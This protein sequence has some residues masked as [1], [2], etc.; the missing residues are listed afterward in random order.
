VISSGASR[1]LPG[2]ERGE[3]MYRTVDVGSPAEEAANEAGRDAAAPPPPPRDDTTRGR[4][5]AIFVTPD[6]KISKFRC[7]APRSSRPQPAEPVFADAPDRD[8]TCGR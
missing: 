2:P 8:R 7:I 4:F 6:D 3:L 1:D 5:E